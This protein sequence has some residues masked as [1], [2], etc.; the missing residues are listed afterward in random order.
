MSRE[1]TEAAARAIRN[2][3]LDASSRGVPVGVTEA[4]D[5]GL[6]R[7][8]DR[9]EALEAEREE[10][11]SRPTPPAATSSATE[12]AAHWKAEAERLRKVL[13]CERGEWAPPGWFWDGVRWDRADHSV[14]VERVAD[15]PPHWHWDDDDLDLYGSE[16]TALEAIEAWRGFADEAA[17][18]NSPERG[19]GER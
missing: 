8:L 18:D 19:E 12:Q 6:C 10:V 16:P 17:V 3:L 15:K 9:V 14:C 4:A 5:L 13:A 2:A 11:W 1:T 7:L